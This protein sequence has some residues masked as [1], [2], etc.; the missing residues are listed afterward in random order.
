MRYAFI[1]AQRG[2]YPV[3][4]L[5]RLLG[6]TEQGFYAWRK[7]PV[8][9]RAVEDRV[10]GDEI[11]MIHA[12]SRQAYG[13]PRVYHELRERGRRCSE[14]RVA[15]L[16]RQRELR[17]RAAR[18][19][20]ATTD[21]THTRPVAENHLNREFSALGPNE[22][23]VGDITYL[24]TKEGWMYLAVFIDLYS[25]IVVGWSLGTRLSADLVLTAWQR[26]CVKRRPGAGLLVHTDRGVQ[27]TAEGFF[28]SFKVGVYMASPSKREEEL[29]RRCSI[30]SSASITG[31][32]GIPR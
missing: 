4:V 31:Y 10:L 5:C 1:A 11:Q 2:G 14:K 32:G 20:R 17:A 25:R 13:S 29:S 15:R 22:R 26:A 6:V 12:E 3:A 30:T 23:W 24:W 28:H 19:W 8:A 21:S 16:M 9:R 7:R 18:K 27:Y